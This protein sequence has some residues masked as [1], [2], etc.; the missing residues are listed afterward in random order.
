[1]TEPLS[2]RAGVRASYCV[3][4]KLRL[5]ASTLRYLRNHSDH[6]PQLNLECQQ[7]L[8]FNRL[9]LSDTLLWLEYDAGYLRLDT[10][11]S[12]LDRAGVGLAS[13]RWSRMRRD[14]YRY[15]DANIHDNARNTDSSCCS[16]SPLRH[17]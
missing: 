10:L 9:W 6:L 4:R 3:R 7:Q 17:R 12:L 16:Q 11:L 8:G 5:D 14:W 1:M 2:Y 15:Q 13:N